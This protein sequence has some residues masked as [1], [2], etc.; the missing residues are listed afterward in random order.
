[1]GFNNTEVEVL[2]YH[3]E[4]SLA[5]YQPKAPQ[6]TVTI[7][8]VTRTENPRYVFVALDVPAATRPGVVPIT[9]SDGKKSITYNYELKARSSDKNRAQGFNSSDVM[10]LIMP[11]RFA[12][13]DPKN[14]SLRG[15]YQGVHRD[16]PFGR[17]GGDLQGIIN[18]LDYIR[19]LGVTTIWLNPVLEN[20]QK[21]ESY[22]GYAITDLYNVD[23]RFGDNELYLDFISKSHQLGLKVV[24]DMVM[25]HIGIEHWLMKDLPSRDWVHQFPSDTRSNY[26]GG[27]IS[28]PYQSKED[29]H[30]MANGWFDSTMPDVN[31]QNELFARYLVQNSIW[32]IEHAGI[33]GIRMDT[34]PYPDK[35][36]MARWAKALLDEFP[37]F[38]IVGEVWLNHVAST[39]YWQKGAV[40]KDGYQSHLPSVTDFPLFFAMQRAFNET[41]GWDNGLVRLYDLLSLDQAYPNPSGNLIFLDNHD[42]TRTF[43]SLG[44]D[45]N[46]LKMAL[47]FLV[48]TRGIPQLYYG[49]EILMEGDGSV[50]PEVRKDYPGGWSND[51]TNA[52]SG[53][54]LSKSQREFRDFMAKL[55]IWRKTSKAVHEGKLVHFIPKDNVYV[56]FRCLESRETIMVLL[57]G[58]EKSMTID[59]SRYLELL[60]K[61]QTGFNPLTGETLSSLRTI[62][63][64]AKGSIILELK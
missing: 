56:Y 19:S 42:V 1:M 31:Q 14:D 40:N 49:T 10:Y 25:N 39:A 3:K 55:L 44:K 43:T 28:D 46:R 17:H 18:N 41:G 60:G 9:F 22:H 26:R 8:R 29:A 6:G 21:R 57:N 38:N 34:Y 11:D 2:F 27:V 20:N 62:E 37:S 36:F 13:G 64:P 33:D 52:F 45:V 12:N 32:W 7:K 61:H 30:I 24:Q 58:N 35:N 59:T 5:N 63:L 54:G 23:R 51:T 48:T 50:H 15:F 53:Q 4:L 47:T 16:K